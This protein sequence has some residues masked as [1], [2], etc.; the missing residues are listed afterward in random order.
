MLLFL[1]KRV[2]SHF[3]ILKE[4]MKI[5]QVLMNSVDNDMLLV[6]TENSLDISV[7]HYAN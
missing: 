2:T 1:Y 4:K 5:I 7:M 3:E 6:V